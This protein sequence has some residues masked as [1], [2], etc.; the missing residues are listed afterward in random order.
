MLS[1]NKCKVSI[2]TV[3]YNGG[4]TIEDT[5]LSVDSQDYPFREHIVIDGASTDNT[6]SVI[7]KHRSRITHFVSE[8]DN[9]IYDAMNKGIKLATGDIIGILNADD[10]Y[11][12]TNCISSVV[13]EFKSK[14]VEA[15]C[16]DLVYVLPDN[17]DKIV[18]YY[19][20]EGFHPDKFAYGI[21]PAHPAFFV[22]RHCYEKYGLFKTDYM[23]AADFELLARFLRTNRV[24][25]YCLPQ[26]LVKMRT[27]GISTKNLKS[28]WILNREIVRACRENNIKTNILKIYSKYI[29]KALQFIKRPDPVIKLQVKL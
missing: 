12:A 28:N 13:H 23:I 29:F 8:P 25:Y 1:E 21:M 27:G 16:G 4:K 11:Y 14:R 18:R 22:D 7:K 6:L 15:V 20:S 9:G 24:K 5:I 19:S 2:I 10:I 3:V 26:V 17:L